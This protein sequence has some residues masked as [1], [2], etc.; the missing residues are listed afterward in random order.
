MVTQL[1]EAATPASPH[2]DI[3]KRTNLG[4]LILSLGMM[5][6]GA[7]IF[8]YIFEAHEKSSSI[9]MALMVVA[10][11]LILYGLFHLFWRSKELVYLPTGSVARASTLF[12]DLKHLG[13]L[14]ELIEQRALSGEASLKAD[15]SGNV[16]LDVVLSGDNKFAAV[17]LFQ[18]VPYS[19]MPVTSVTYYTGS[20]AAAIA[21][22]VVK[23]RAA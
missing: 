21:A 23:C 19:Y 1:L 14:T 4:A 11:A 16:R 2:P 3:A 17:Q 12:F 22:F 15:A 10:S 7:L 9:S 20:E 8:L 13:R 6:A 5:L 18:F